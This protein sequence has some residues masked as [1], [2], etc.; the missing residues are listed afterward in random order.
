[1]SAPRLTQ[2]LWV[3]PESVKK[4]IGSSQQFR[5]DTLKAHTALS[6]AVRANVANGT[7]KL[8]DARSK[9]PVEIPPLPVKP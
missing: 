7:W 4:R 2:G 3:L 8:I 1:M 9:K 5:Y 6:E